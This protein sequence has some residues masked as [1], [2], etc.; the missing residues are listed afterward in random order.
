MTTSKNPRLGELRPS[1]IL[2]TYGVGA[3]VDLPHLSVIVAGLEDWNVNDG[4][5]RGITEE[6]VLRATASRPAIWKEPSA[7]QR[8]ATLS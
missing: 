5:A 1:Q 2:F 6:R 3:L 7:S 4:N 8:W